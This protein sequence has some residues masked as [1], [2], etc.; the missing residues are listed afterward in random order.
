MPLHWPCLPV[1]RGLDGLGLGSFQDFKFI[2]HKSV[3]VAAMIKGRVEKNE[4][5]RVSHPAVGQ[6]P[7]CV[8]HMLRLS[9]VAKSVAFGLDRPGFEF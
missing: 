8:V 9:L 7:C 2:G 4:R 5:K 6:V 1:A 3:L